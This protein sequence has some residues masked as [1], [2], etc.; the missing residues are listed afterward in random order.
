METAKDKKNPHATPRHL[1]KPHVLEKQGGVTRNKAICGTSAPT[2]KSSD[3]R[4]WDL[5]LETG[6]ESA[7]RHR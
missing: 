6:A 4:P 7:A 3:V 5:T 2:D 1:K